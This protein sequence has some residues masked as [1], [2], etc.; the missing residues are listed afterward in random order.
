MPT[1][2]PVSD[3]KLQAIKS[4]QP[5]ESTDLAVYGT[6]DGIGIILSVDYGRHH[7]SISRPDRL[8]SWEDV[9]AA[10]EMFLPIGKHF[11]MALPPPQHYVNM[12]QY[13]L[14]LWELRPDREPDLIWTFEQG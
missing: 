4:M 3:E 11:V 5:K 10:R 8:P 2:I 14:H 13:V 7:M 1:Y 6:K 12:H 9:K